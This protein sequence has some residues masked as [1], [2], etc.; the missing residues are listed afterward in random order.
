MGCRRLPF[1]SVC[2]AASAYIAMAAWGKK[3]ARVTFS[4]IRCIQVIVSTVLAEQD[5][6]E[7]N[8]VHAHWC[9]FGSIAVGAS[10]VVCLPNLEWSLGEILCSQH[11]GRRRCHPPRASHLPYGGHIDHYGITEASSGSSLTLLFP[12]SLAP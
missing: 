8:K 3:M 1:D 7:S 12:P 4:I 5:R 11:S 2:R 6:L 9:P 10:K